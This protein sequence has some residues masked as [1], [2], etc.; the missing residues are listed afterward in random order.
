MDTKTKDDPAPIATVMDYAAAIQR[1]GAGQ[2]TGRIPAEGQRYFASC[3]GT[4]FF[5]LSRFAPEAI[6]A[7]GSNLLIVAASP[8]LASDGGRWVSL[9]A[10]AI[11]PTARFSTTICVP[12]KPPSGKAPKPLLF[13]PPQQIL[14][15]DWER[16]LEAVDNPPDVVVIHGLSNGA[17][18]PALDDLSRL[19]PGAKLLVACSSLPQALVAHRLITLHGFGSPDVFNFPLSEASAQHYAPGAWWVA[20]TV[21]TT[22]EN[23]QVAPDVLGPL[24]VASTTFHRQMASTHTQLD[25]AATAEIYATRTTETIDGVEGIRAVRL[26]PHQGISLETGRYFSEREDADGNHACI[27]EDKSVDADLLALSPLQ[28]ADGRAQDDRLELML[29][30][31]MAIAEGVRRNEA[32][33]GEAGANAMEDTPASEPVPPDDGERPSPVPTLAA[34]TEVPAAA[35]V[36]TPV[37]STVSK[38][39]WRVRLP[40]GAGTVNV[41]AMAAKLGTVD[42]SSGQSFKDAQQHILGWLANKKFGVL[43]ALTNH[44]V[45]HADGEV[46]IETNGEDI[47]SMRFDDRSAMDSGAIWRVELTLVGKGTAAMSLRMAQVR[48]SEDA[49]LP[50]ASGVPSVVVKIAQTVGLRDAGAALIDSAQSLGGEGDAQQLIQL[51]LNPHRSQ[52]VIVISGSVDQSADRLAKRLAGVAH[53]VRI[54][55]TMSDRLIRAFGRDRSVFGNAIR[56]YR[57]GFTADADPYQHPVWGI[58]GTQLPKWMANDLFELACAISLDVGDLEERAP[59]FP[60]IRNLLAQFRQAA[61]D[62]RLADLRQQA[63]SIASSAEGQIEQLQAI[64]R[65]LETALAEQ[66]AQHKHLLEQAQQARDELQATLN[67]R[68]EALEEIR[69]LKFQISNQWNSFEPEY[70]EDDNEV[71]YPDSW[72]DLEDWV[73]IYGQD[74]LVLHPKAAKA[75]RESPFKDIPFAYKAMEYLVNHYIPMRT[76]DPDDQ[77]TYEQ[78]NRAL[79]ELGLEESD[80]GTAK[81]IKRYKHEYRRQYE[82]REVT[83]DRHLKCGVGFGGDFQFRLYFHYDAAAEKV[84]IGHLPTHLTNRLSHNG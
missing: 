39:S 20:S 61:S 81:D 70:V 51:L 65:E 43:D 41:L 36:V 12:I 5:A 68:N 48:S 18:Q 74:R 30:L 52:S 14:V 32:L 80:V 72:D 3:Y 67:E 45:E 54:D 38:P 57:P 13:Q 76:R 58:K 33:A 83:L 82:G 15:K 26:S 47:W 21:P 31:G 27:W 53:V 46:T 78:S 23:A 63:D 75:A 29:W 71:V 64:N 59:S 66:R 8:V 84:L 28:D 37:K 1:V 50:V 35:P 34:A 49:P 62:Q 16:H 56:L 60:T 7:Q 2:F 6:E 40:R 10:K 77:E 11:C 25:T 22:A 9:Y 79:A 19:T 73:E 69:Q 4:L 44:H 17:L 24:M 42:D 55:S